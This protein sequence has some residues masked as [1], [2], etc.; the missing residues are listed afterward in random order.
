MKTDSQARKRDRV[1]T[2]KRFIDVLFIF[3]AML[4]VMNPSLADV[5][6]INN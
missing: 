5:V 3:I 1:L 4:I 6:N 2:W